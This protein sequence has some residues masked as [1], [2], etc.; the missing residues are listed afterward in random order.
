MSA[1][2]WRNAFDAATIVRARTDAAAARIA[3]ELI[4]ARLQR[5]QDTVFATVRRL[6]RDPEAGDVAQVGH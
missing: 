1:P 4:G 3:L 2:N 5:A 6:I